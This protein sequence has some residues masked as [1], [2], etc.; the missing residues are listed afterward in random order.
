[1]KII[2][3]LSTILAASI[4]SVGCAVEAPAS[5]ES[6]E[7]DVTGQSEDALTRA[8]V[9]GTY[10]R[11]THARGCA[12]ANTLELRANGTF[13]AAVDYNGRGAACTALVALP[14]E[15]TYAVNASRVVAFRPT[16][17]AA[18][19][20]LRLQAGAFSGVTGSASGR[21]P[22]QGRFQKLGADECVNDASCTPNKS[23]SFPLLSPAAPGT[24]FVYPPVST[25]V[26]VIVP[27]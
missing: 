8:S 15:G 25:G 14:F 26:C 12:L 20:A 27:C 18:A 24:T 5:P 16:G 11:T 3:A 17:G 9:V 1:M 21:R 7:T 10:Y 23:C 6:E 19:F 2:L 13:S 4:L 22:F